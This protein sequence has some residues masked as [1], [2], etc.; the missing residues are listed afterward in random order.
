M[1]LFSDLQELEIEDS[2]IRLE[3]NANLLGCEYY[4]IVDGQKLD[5]SKGMFGTLYLHGRLKEGEESNITV[6]IKQSFFATKYAVHYK[7][8]EFT[9]RKI[10]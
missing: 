3:A 1:G 6:V 2:R 8:K 10:H 5:K 4:L 7:G 9:P